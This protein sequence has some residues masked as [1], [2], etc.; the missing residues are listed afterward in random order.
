MTRDCTTAWVSRL[1]LHYLK[2][3]KATMSPT[4]VKVLPEDHPCA[5]PVFNAKNIESLPLHGAHNLPG[6]TNKKLH[7]SMMLRMGHGTERLF[8]A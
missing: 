2:K 7:C 3:K 6:D 8:A 5:G 4:K 1:K